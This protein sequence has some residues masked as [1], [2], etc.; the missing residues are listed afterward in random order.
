MALHGKEQ[1]YLERHGATLA[2][3]LLF[4]NQAALVDKEKSSIMPTLIRTL[5]RITEPPNESSTTK[6]QE[7]V[8]SPQN[9]L[10]DLVHRDSQLKKNEATSSDPSDNTTAFTANDT[11]E[12][13]LQWRILMRV[14]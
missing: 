11:S 14:M 5:K 6:S 10:R 7:V 13:Y 2:S 3:G 4:T 12:A 9:N 8:R 1:R